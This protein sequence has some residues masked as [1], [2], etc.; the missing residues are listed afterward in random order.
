MHC[1]TWRTNS[2]PSVWSL[3][4]YMQIADMRRNRSLCGPLQELRTAAVADMPP[5]AILQRPS[6]LQNILPLL[7]SA[8]KGSLL[9]SAALRL[10]RCLV[11]H[12]KWALAMATDPL[13]L[14]NCLGQHITASFCCTR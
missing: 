1:C 2:A 5:E 3:P 14:P 6:V 4:R 7:Q 9:P 11:C 13:Y 10:L 12:I 8:D